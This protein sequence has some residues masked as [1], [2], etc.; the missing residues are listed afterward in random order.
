MFGTCRG[1]ST[2]VKQ[3]LELVEKKWRLLDAFRS[4]LMALLFFFFSPLDAW[5]KAPVLRRKRR[6]MPPEN[7]LLLLMSVEINSSGTHWQ[8]S[9]RLDPVV[10]GCSGSSPALGVLLSFALGSLRGLEEGKYLPQMVLSRGVLLKS[11]SSLP[12]PRD[13]RGCP[14][15]GT[16]PS[17]MLLRFP[18]G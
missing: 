18:G 11:S 6:E 9:G 17:L 3:Q 4:L 16:Q 12:A 13:T 15:H 8:G 1:W 5:Q 14:P 2:L 10:Q 7:V